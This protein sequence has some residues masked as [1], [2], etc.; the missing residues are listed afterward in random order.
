MRTIYI[1]VTIQLLC[2]G[3]LAYH[4]RRNEIHNRISREA[5][6]SL[7]TRNELLLSELNLNIEQQFG[8]QQLPHVLA[9]LPKADEQGIVLSVKKI[10][11]SS[12]VIPYNASLI[13]HNGGYQ[14]FFRYDIP[15]AGRSKAPFHSYIGYAKLN[16]QF[17]LSDP[18][19]HVVDTESNFSED[20][21]VIQH[22][23]RR[24]LVFND[25]IP[26]EKRPRSIWMGE[27]NQEY[28]IVH[29]VSP[30]KTNP[31][32]TEKNWSPFFYEGDL[33]FIYSINPHQ[34]L[35]YPSMAPVNL[36]SESMLSDCDWPTN[37][38]GTLR[39][40]TPAQLVDGEYLAFFHSA[41]SDRKGLDWYVMGAYTFEATPPFRITR[42]S[43]YPILFKGI[44][45]SPHL[46][47]SN[48][49]IRV[50]Y[51]A[52]FVTDNERIHVSCGENDS[53]VK[54]LTLDKNALLNSL[55]RVGGI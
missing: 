26:M 40:G 31:S 17:D 25:V 44:Y 29:S 55:K 1:L 10:A 12:A 6:L 53:A 24:F 30:L 48:P 5:L 52:G 35:K 13:A 38:W 34:V 22:G 23:D 46:N 14:L 3:A 33:H 49:R 47:T 28:K 4:L 20:P 41:F 2:V 9:R 8:C 42:I 54:I 43:P 7:I 37:M 15:I 50:L 39:G 11:I 16:N 32:R 18:Q 21:R 51:P 19:L 45:D 27:L 36:G